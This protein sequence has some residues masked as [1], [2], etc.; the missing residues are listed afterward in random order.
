MSR[1]REALTSGGTRRRV[2]EL[3]REAASGAGDGWRSGEEI[4]SL[5]GLSRAAVG[6]H[7]RGLREGG[8][9]IDAAPRRGYRLIAEK[10]A[11]SVE[12]VRAGLRSR[13]LGQGRWIWLEETDTT[14]N[15]AAR[16][17]M[18]GAEEG[19]VVV[20][21]RQSSGKGR[22]GRSWFSAPRS[23]AFTVVLRPVRVDAERVTRM[24]LESVCE[25]VRE[26]SGLAPVLKEPNDVLLD[27]RKICGVLAESGHR[28]DELEWLVIGIGVNVNAREEDFAPEIRERAG[29]LL[30]ASGL[31]ADRAGLLR[32][33]L[34][35]LDERYLAAEGR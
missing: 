22:K 20:A 10:E 18:E 17:A 5:L 32:A 12:A 21:G 27:G 16:A 34:E 2:L 28:A 19:C 4:S 1:D 11:F 9:L 25:A 3:L 30:I 6:K 7:V 29:S 35:R 15:V 24:A 8:F 13:L 26:V 23:L 14:N 31:P 33:V